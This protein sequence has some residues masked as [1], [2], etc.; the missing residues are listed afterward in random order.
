MTERNV[1]P[2]KRTLFNKLI[3]GKMVILLLLLLLLP[4]LVIKLCYA[5]RRESHE[6]SMLPLL[7][8]VI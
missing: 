6:L 3:G 1:L 2:G 8:I 5:V 4:F 7:C